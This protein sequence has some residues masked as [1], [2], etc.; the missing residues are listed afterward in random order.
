[1]NKKKNRGGDDRDRRQKGKEN[2][3]K[4]RGAVGKG[5]KQRG[6][7]EEQNRGETQEK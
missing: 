1:M 7:R 4:Q 5:R 3:K 6:K 2:T